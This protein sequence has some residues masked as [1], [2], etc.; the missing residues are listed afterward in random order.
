MK[1][2]DNYMSEKIMLD[3]TDVMGMMGICKPK[4]YEVFKS[5]EFHVIKMGRKYLVHKEVFEGWLKGN[6]TKKKARW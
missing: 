4:A 6:S 2:E 5:G 1:G 3:V